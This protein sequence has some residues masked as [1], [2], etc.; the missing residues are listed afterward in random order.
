MKKIILFVLF[1]TT[2]LT[3]LGQIAFWKVKPTFD[4]VKPLQNGIIEVKIG[5]KVG[6][7]NFVGETLLPVSYDSIG[8]FVDNEALL[9][10][11]SRFV[12]F[13]NDDG[14]LTDLT[15]KGYK[16]VKNQEFFSQGFLPVMKDGQYYFLDR[17]GVEV[18]GPFAEVFPYFG[19]LAVIQAYTDMVKKPN[20]KFFSY[21]N[22]E[23]ILVEIPECD[24]RDELSFLSSFRDGRAVCIYKKK[25]YYV[26]SDLTTTP[27]SLDTLNSK[28]TV[29]AFES[30]IVNPESV[31]GNYVIN[32]KNAVLTFNP[33]LQLERIESGE[34]VIYA[35]Q[36][37]GQEPTSGSDELNRMENNG[38]CGLTYKGVPIL[39]PQFSDVKLLDGKLALVKLDNKWGIVEVDTDNKFVFKLNDNE[40]IGFNHRFYTTKLAALMPSYIKC[41]TTTIVSKSPDCEIQVESRNEIENIERNTLTYDCKLSIPPSLSD[42]LTTQEYTFAVKYDGLQSVDYKVSVPEWYVKYYE[43]VVPNTNFTVQPNDTIVVEFDLVKTDVARNDETNY[44]KTVEVLSA[45]NEDIPV[46]KIT[47]NHYSFR[48][49]SGHNDRLSFVVRI[50]ETGCPTIEYPYEMVFTKPAPKSKDK[51]VSVTVNPIKRSKTISKTPEKGNQ[52]G[53]KIFVPKSTSK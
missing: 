51:T 28:K 8:A 32:A 21:M 6:L 10:N 18:A 23:Q 7:C 37:S 39:A 13:V 11:N 26:S 17:N 12:G 1:S 19:G 45:D 15:S 36:S 50:T 29:I 41:K 35:Y 49:G 40:H 14:Q 3:S 9:F 46:N 5:K 4:E 44:F 24:K 47:E 25:A 43:V 34:D 42:T 53:E 20:E 22:L 38:K 27:I 2:V 52:T 31:E 33:Q 16:L 48:V 30:K